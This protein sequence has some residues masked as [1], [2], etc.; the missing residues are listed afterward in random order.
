MNN[1]A[2]ARFPLKKDSFRTHFEGE[3][4]A[5]SVPVGYTPEQLRR[6]Y[7]Y[8]ASYTGKGKK[9]A[10]ICAFDNAAIEENMKSFCNE[11]MLPV[12][13]MSLYYPYGK[14]ESTDENWRIESSLDT[15]WI[16]VFAPSAEIAVIFAKSGEVEELLKCASYAANEL[17]ADVVNMSFGREETARDR[18]LS[19]IFSLS[20][21]IF[22]S[23]SGDVG[24]RV[25]FPSS[26]CFCIS[27]GGSA[28]SLT[29]NNNRL[30]ETAW[31]NGGGGASNVFETPRWQGRFYNIFGMSDGKRATPD[32]SMNS[33]FIKGV[34]VYDAESGGWLTLGGTSLACA[35]FSGVCACLCQAKENI[36][37]SEDALVYLYEK[38]GVVEYDVSGYGFYDITIGSNE[39]YRAERGYDF[40]TGLGS[41]NVALLVK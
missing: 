14:T 19:Q 17:K 28:L 10:V 21:S 37:T 3:K 24:G 7:L 34:P 30:E 25:S 26:S 33:S 40:C 23:S 38:A 6:A 18:E 20:N 41:P 31:K 11:F 13:K 32:V 15:Q 9:I 39:V 12:S 16:H 36:K 29:S 35:C 8:D 2:V 22:N 27:V 1:D 4:T 5:G